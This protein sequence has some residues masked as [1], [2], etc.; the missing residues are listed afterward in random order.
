MNFR[1]FS[2]AALAEGLTGDRDWDDARAFGLDFIR[3][4]AN[5]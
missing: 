3:A 1:Q 2:L 4:K 5:P